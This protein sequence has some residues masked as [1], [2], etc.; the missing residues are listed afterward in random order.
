MIS[1]LDRP[2]V[3]ALRNEI[4]Q[5]L[6]LIG[7]QHGVVISLGSAKFTPSNAT[8]KLEVATKTQDGDVQTKEATAFKMLAKAYDLEPSDLGRTFVSNG[9]H[10]TITGLNPKRPKYPIC[11][12]CKEDGRSYKFPEKN[13]KLLMGRA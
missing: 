5:A 12:T 13:V 2:A 1:Q 8:F 6:A 10:F 9:R 4:N 7:A 11:A 3:L